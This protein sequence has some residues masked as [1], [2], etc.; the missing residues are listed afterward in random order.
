MQETWVRSPGGEEPL[1]KEMATA[2][3]VLTWGTPWAEE[4]GALQTMGS[5]SDTA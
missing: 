3:N 1:E 5:E 2:S 4:P